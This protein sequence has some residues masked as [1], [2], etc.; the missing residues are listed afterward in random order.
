MGTSTK[1]VFLTF[2]ASAK[3]LVPLLLSV[4]KAENQLAPFVIICLT[5]AKVSTLLMT[6]GLPHNPC[7]VGNG[8]LG[9]GVPLCPSI[10]VIR[11]VSSPQTNAPAPCFISISKE[12]PLSRIRSPKSVLFL[13]CDMALFSLFSAN[14][15]YA[16]Q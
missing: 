9:L 6:V 7:C 10:D 1:P 15:Y 16:L 13:A 12:N 14:G 8:G 11:A 5:L 3:T 2:P 4:P